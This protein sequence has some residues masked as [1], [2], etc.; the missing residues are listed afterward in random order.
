MKL[1]LLE[2]ESLGLDVSMEPFRAF[3]TLIEYPVADQEALADRIR[4]ADIVLANKSKLTREVLEQAHRL[5]MIAELATGY[6]NIDIAYCKERGIAVANAGHYST[7][8]VV[9]HTFAMALFLL[10]K[11]RHYDDV[12]K[13]GAYAS[14][15]NFSIFDSPVIELAGKTWGIAGYGEIGR[16]VAQVA[17]AFGCKVIAASTSGTYLEGRVSLEE[18]FRCSDILSLHCPLTDRTRHLI[19]AKALAM[20]KPGAILINVAR[21]PVVDQ[22]ALYEAL[23]EDRIAGAGLDVLEEEPMAKDNPLL[24]IQDSRKL[25][26]TPHMA[27]ASVEARTRDVMISAENIRAF[28]AGEKRNRVV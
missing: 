25:I 23:V 9:Q 2:R 7:T 22:E 11:L 27:W 17:R 19:D 26:I 3:G 6:D 24:K 10:G 18:L 28:L 4:D 12:V 21:G 8:A 5:R 20:M 15:N 1:V 16:G 13:S 14:Q